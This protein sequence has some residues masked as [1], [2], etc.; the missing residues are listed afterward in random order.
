MPL[1]MNMICHREEIESETLHLRLL[2]LKKKVLLKVYKSTPV[3][4]ILAGHRSL[5]TIWVSW[6]VKV[7]ADFLN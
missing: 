4:Q 2:P 1:Y 6:P 5:P 3:L 7:D